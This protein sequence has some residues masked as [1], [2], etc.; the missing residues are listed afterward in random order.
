MNCCNLSNNNA[1]DNYSKKVGRIDDCDIE[2]IL[3]CLEEMA[4]YRKY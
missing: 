3:G 2:I 1:F 4:Y